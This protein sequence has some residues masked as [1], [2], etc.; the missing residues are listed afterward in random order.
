MKTIHNKTPLMLAVESRF[1]LPI[2]ELLRQKYVDE[3]LTF[4]QISD[5]IG[6]GLLTLKQWVVKAGIW[7]RRLDV[8]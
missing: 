5:E 7:S 4:E 1:E 8:P 6:I 3:S 2:E